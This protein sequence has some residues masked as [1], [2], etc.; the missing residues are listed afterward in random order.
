MQPRKAL[1]ALAIV[2][3]IVSGCAALKG[4]TTPAAKLA[5]QSA[6][7]KVIDSDTERA[8]RV[9]KIAGQVLEIVDGNAEATLDAVEKRVRDE[10]RW[11]QL[12][13]AEQLVASNLVDAVRVEIEARID[14]GT[15]APDDRVV[16]QKV[17]TWIRE[18]SAMAVGGSR[19]ATG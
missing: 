10:I 5:I 15:L 7:L 9:H 16:V 4:D 3:L 19:A 13:Q 11:D 6:T 18:A 12:D 1:V 8:Q 2:A 14:G 17:M